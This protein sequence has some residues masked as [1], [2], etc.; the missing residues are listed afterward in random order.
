[1]PIDTRKQS[2]K[3]DANNVTDGT[4]GTE[5][6]TIDDSNIETTSS[7][8]LP[9]A[10]KKNKNNNL[11]QVSDTEEEFDNSV[12]S[13]SVSTQS[14]PKTF[15]EAMKVAKKAEGELFRTYRSL[16]AGEMSMLK[17]FGRKCFTLPDVLSEV[18]M[19]G[20][21]EFKRFNEELRSCSFKIK[22][23]Q[24]MLSY[25]EGA[26]AEDAALTVQAAL[27]FLEN[28]LDRDVN[29]LNKTPGCISMMI[30][31]FEKPV[32]K[33]LFGKSEADKLVVKLKALMKMRQVIANVS[34]FKILTW[35]AQRNGGGKRS[36]G[37]KNEKEDSEK[38]GKKKRYDRKE[39]Y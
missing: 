30:L 32:N 36:H 23:V 34:A 12:A 21:D 39:Q 5:E 16:Q 3:T 14:L 2:Q 31:M 19:K 11:R 22:T 8:P 18:L 6:T 26:D 10:P 1:M 28:W 25:S 15:R 13:T 37:K 24:D 27:E 38:T 33:F 20:G 4:D 17:E 35:S 29:L 7:T 9:K